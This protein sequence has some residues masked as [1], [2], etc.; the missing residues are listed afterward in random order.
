MLVHR[1][2]CLSIRLKNPS[3]AKGMQLSWNAKGFSMMGFY[4]REIRESLEICS[5]TKKCVLEKIC[6]VERKCI[7]WNQVINLRILPLA[8]AQSFTKMH[9]PWDTF[10]NLLARL[11]LHVSNQYNKLL[12]IFQSH[13]FLR[14]PYPFTCDFSTQKAFFHFCT[15]NSSYFSFQLLSNPDAT[16]LILLDRVG[17]LFLFSHCTIMVVFTLCCSF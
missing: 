9:E 4:Q 16:S 6:M 11:H 1:M 10:S 2:C 17:F 7:S 15:W 5:Q 8:H 13:Y 12:V 14:L 3:C